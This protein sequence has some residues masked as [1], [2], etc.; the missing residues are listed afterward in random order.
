LGTISGKKKKYSKNTGAAR[1]K[2]I[3]R[4]R[5]SKRCQGCLIMNYPTWKMRGNPTP[6]ETLY[7]CDSCK[8]SRWCPYSESIRYCYNCRGKKGGYQRLRKATA[9][10]IAEAKKVLKDII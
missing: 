8:K 2:R 6:N 10:E 7:C 3:V 1:D 5:K 4:F 9:K